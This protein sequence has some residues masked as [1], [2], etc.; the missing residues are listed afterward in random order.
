MT[1]RFDAAGVRNLATFLDDA[2]RRW[3]DQPW[4]HTPSGDVSRAETL[5]NA[6]SIAGSL[7]DR[8][9]RPND[10]VVVVLP[11]SIEFVEVWFALVLLGA[12]T[13]AIDLYLA[14]KKASEATPCHNL[15]SLV[16]SIQEAIPGH[17]LPPNGDWTDWDKAA[18]VNAVAKDNVGRSVESVLADSPTIAAMSDRGVIAVRGCFYNIGSGE[19]EFL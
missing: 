14:R 9:A 1:I 19:V 5:A 8:G 2:A 16:A 13:S 10:R 7:R 4:L 3:P 11:N 15:D 17:K 6:R 12:V 18:S